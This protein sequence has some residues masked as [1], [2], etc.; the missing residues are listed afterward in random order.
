[1]SGYSPQTPKDFRNFV[2]MVW[3]HLKLPSPTALQFDIAHYLQHG[4][5]RACIEAFR[6]EGKSWLT[7]AYVC[8]RL[9]Q[10]PD[11]NILVV[12]ASKTRADD[13]SVFV[14]R[15]I[16]EMPCLQHLVPK[17]NQRQSKISFDVGPAKASHAPSV[18]SLGVTSQL[19]GSRADLIVADDIEV[20]N[21]SQTQPMRDKL[22]EA[23]KEFD[24]ILKPGG[25]VVFLGTPQCE[26]SLYNKLPER[27]YEVRVWPARFPDEKREKNYGASLAPSIVQKL[28]EGTAKV[29]APTD[30]VRFSDLDLRE[31][32]ASYGRAGFALQFMLDTNLSDLEKYP[33]RLSDL[34]IQSCDAEMAAEKYVWAASPELVLHDLPNV[35][36]KGDYY[37]RPMQIVGKYVA[38]QGSVMAIDP[39]GRG[40]DETAYAVVKM[41][42]GQLFL[43]ACGGLPGYGEDTMTKL[44]KIAELHKVNQI[45]I[46]ENFGDG[47]FTAMF[48]PI[49]AGIYDCTTE[50][51]KHSKQKEHRICD[52]LEP[53]MNA[54]KLIVD[55]KVIEA[56]LK[57]VQ[58]LPSESAYK[59]QL[60]HQL[61]RI[62]RDKG[63]LSHDDRLDALAMAVAYWV[64]QMGVESQKAMDN[65]K[66]ADLDAALE[67]FM[68]QVI[69]R[70]PVGD[71]WNS[72]IMRY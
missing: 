1:M 70:K 71:N 41:L 53:V 33:L 3:Q 60:F 20:P 36:M 28:R 12:S 40:K 63:A 21:N 62:T 45:V 14:L 17:D 32:E 11:T 23:V 59:Y 66:A 44:A 38:Y 43:V 39:S 10:D 35:G 51:V 69:G 42:D 67:K 34:I 31:R 55:P 29:G 27:G 5:R 46:E 16:H 7:S 30:A 58:D 18:K 13:F 4:P 15:L 49:L 24:A 65:R 54:H 57:S 52:T 64:E 19:A 47:M 25:R 6:G 56:D 9:D 37:Y 68:G 2:F 72:R 50:E 8:W 22:S 61:T 26:M 48:R